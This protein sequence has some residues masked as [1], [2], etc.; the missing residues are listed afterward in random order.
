MI[1][2]LRFIAIFDVIEI[3]KSDRSVS[4]IALIDYEFYR[5]KYFF[6]EL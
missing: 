1:I 6:N 3:D 2:S 5:V 4:S